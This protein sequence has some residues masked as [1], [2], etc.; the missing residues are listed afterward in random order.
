MRLDPEIHGENGLELIDRVGLG[1][2]GGAFDEH[3]LH[4]VRDRVTGGVEHAQLRVPPDGFFGEVEAGLEVALQL[5]VREQDIDCVVGV[6]NRQGF[7]GSGGRK[8]MMACS[9][10]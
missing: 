3:G 1:K 5:D 7:A 8:C 9:W 4:S 2:E 6:E 10:R